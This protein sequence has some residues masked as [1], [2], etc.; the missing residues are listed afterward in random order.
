[1][2]KNDVYCFCNMHIPSSLFSYRFLFMF[3]FVVV[4]GNNSEYTIV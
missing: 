3:D 1:M 2:D 4:V